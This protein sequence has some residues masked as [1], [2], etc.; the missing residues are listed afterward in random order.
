[1]SIGYFVFSDEEDCVGTFYPVTYSLVV[2]VTDEVLVFHLFSRFVV[3]DGEAVV[4]RC[5]DGGGL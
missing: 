3:C 4:D 5:F 2:G 1:M